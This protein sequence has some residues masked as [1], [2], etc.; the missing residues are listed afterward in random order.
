MHAIYTVQTVAPLL[1]R[2]YKE[3]GAAAAE[4]RVRRLINAGIVPVLGS[5]AK[6]GPIR[7]S[8]AVVKDLLGEGKA[9]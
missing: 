9:L 2:N 7:I 4:Q 3:I 6:G 8:R 5:R 1:I